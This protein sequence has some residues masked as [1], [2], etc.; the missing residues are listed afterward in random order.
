MSHWGMKFAVK[1]EIAKEVLPFDVFG[2]KGV[3]PFDCHRTSDV[4]FY[5]HV[6]QFLGPFMAISTF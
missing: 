1:S 6:L 3:L 4:C 2:S 5:R